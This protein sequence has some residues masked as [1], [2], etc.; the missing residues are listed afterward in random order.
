ML[1]FIQNSLAVLLLAACQTDKL[2]PDLIRGPTG[3]W[4]LLDSGV[5]RN[6]EIQ[7]SSDVR[8]GLDGSLVSPRY[9]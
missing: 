4:G 9:C 5:R 6:D 3:C 1:D 7:W 2:A 8:S